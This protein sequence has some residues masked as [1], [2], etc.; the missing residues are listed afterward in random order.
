[1]LRD[2]VRACIFTALA[3]CVLLS[4]CDKSGSDP[5]V[6]KTSAGSTRKAPKKPTLAEQMVAA[7]STT[8]SATVIGV[9]F[10]LGNSPTINQAL[11]VDIVLVPHEKLAKVVGHF[12]GQDGITV[13]SGDAMEPK[14]EVSAEST[15]SH[16]L[17]LM[18]T[19]TGVFMVSASIETEGSEG[20]VSRV[21][22]IP[23]IVSP[24]LPP[25]PATTPE[26]PASQ[27]KPQI[28]ATN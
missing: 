24:P 8:R 2:G 25:A 12:D 10:S 7:V 13:V 21:F 3:G 17:V 9:Y 11:P 26:P 16:K 28:P 6:S 5:D 22:S 15:L 4:A 20:T 27:G 18:P 19:K 14:T 1:M 23:V